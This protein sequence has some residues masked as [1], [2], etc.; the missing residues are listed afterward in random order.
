MNIKF[1]LI[2]FF[3][4]ILS[5][6]LFLFFGLLLYPSISN[7]A[8]ILQINDPSTILIGDQ[9][10]NLTINLYCSEVKE[11]NEVNALNLLKENFPRGTKVKI[12]PLGYKGDYLSARVFKMEDTTEMTKLLSDNKLSNENCSN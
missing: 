5:N 3:K 12:K 11:E 9:N 6:L 7:S 8:E 4:K 2:E 10:R 1:N